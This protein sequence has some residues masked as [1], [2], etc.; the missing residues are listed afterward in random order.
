MTMREL[1]LAEA[2]AWRTI[3]ERIASGRWQHAGLCAEVTACE[4]MAC[5]F[6]Q[7]MDRV[8]RHRWAARFV[9]HTGEYA[10]DDAHV[11]H[12]WGWRRGDAAPRVLAC[13][14]LALE[15][16]DDA[17]ARRAQATEVA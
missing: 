9:E 14:F 16:E 4:D 10:S 8:S 2:R 12:M 17:D 3:A 5:V 7:A 13:L 15:A 6:T 11:Y 1:Y